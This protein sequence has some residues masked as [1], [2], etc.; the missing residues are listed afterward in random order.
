MEVTLEA[1]KA[2][3]D[4]LL[5][6]IF[7]PETAPQSDDP[8]LQAIAER[9]LRLSRQV[10]E[11]KE[12]ALAMAR[13]Q[14]DVEFPPRSNYL[15]YGLKE[16]H[17]N[18]L[19]LVW[20]VE[21]ITHGNYTQ[22]VDFMGQISDAFNQMASVLAKRDLQLTQSQ[23]IL[24]IILSF[25]DISLFVLEK[26]SGKLLHGRENLNNYSRLKDMPK[27]TAL[28][29]RQLQEHIANRKDQFE[30]WQ[31]QN[32]ENN[33]WYMVKSMPGV[34]GH[35]KDA[36]YHVLT[37][38]SK[39]IDLNKRLEDAM[40][41]DAKF[42]DSYNQLYAVKYISTLM[43]SHSN[44]AV[45]YLDLDNFKQINDQKGHE[46][47]DRYI[48]SIIDIVRSVIRAQD[49][50]CRIG[51][52]EF[53][54]ILSGIKSKGALRIIDR[55]LE[56]IDAFN[57]LDKSDIPLAFSYGIEMVDADG[58]DPKPCASHACRERQ[59]GTAQC[60]INKADKKMYRQKRRKNKIR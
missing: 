31:L 58:F 17:A 46:E 38:I 15:A 24:E 5:C 49:V 26:D 45:C 22:K 13:G 7:L 56:K 35:D 29:V 34:W 33:Q 16:L 20:K 8:E 51:G 59:C 1:L 28:L 27:D 47:G 48:R 37:N 19:H 60:I 2:W 53:L 44:F 55:L 25:A 41:R 23:K 18:M 42:T 43:Q 12:Y 30:E 4:G 50:F 21:Q 9:I 39:T 52:D 32:R 10:E 6:G 14:L 57:K 11:L 54:L 40:N 36:Y 3:L